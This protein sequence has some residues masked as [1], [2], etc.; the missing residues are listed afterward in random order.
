MAPIGL[1]KSWSLC[2]DGLSLDLSICDS[3][4]QKNMTDLPFLKGTYSTLNISGYALLPQSSHVEACLLFIRSYLHLVP[5]WVCWPYVNSHIGKFQ[6]LKWMISQSLRMIW[7]FAWIWKGR[8]LWSTI[9]THQ[10]SCSSKDAH[11]LAFSHIK[12]IQDGPRKSFLVF[13]DLI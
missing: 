10:T 13:L 8:V 9:D 11:F 7:E 3:N 1:P 5:N 12:V 6:V 4:L 2:C